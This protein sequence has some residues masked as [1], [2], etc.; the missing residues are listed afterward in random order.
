MNHPFGFFIVRLSNGYVT[1]KTAVLMDNIAHL[2][3]GKIPCQA[4]KNHK[5][6]HGNCFFVKENRRPAP[7]F[8]IFVNQKGTHKENQ[9]IF[10]R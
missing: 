1:V 8:Q 3:K 10:Q 9:G 4:H 6:H 2:G 5:H 7:M